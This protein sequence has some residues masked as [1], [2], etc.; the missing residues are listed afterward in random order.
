MEASLFGGVVYFL[1][2]QYGITVACSK[3]CLKPPMHM[4]IAVTVAM[5]FLFPQDMVERAL[6]D[7]VAGERVA[8]PGVYLHQMPYPCYKKDR[9]A[10]RAGSHSDTSLVL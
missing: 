8:S 5:V 3:H 2:G 6:V 1:P 4:Y 10:T 7:E 9:S